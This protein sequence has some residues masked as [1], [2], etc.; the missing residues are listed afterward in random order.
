VSKNEAKRLTEYALKLLGRKSYSEAQIREKLSAKTTDK[1]CVDEAVKNLRSWRLIDDLEFAKGFIRNSLLVRPKGVRRLKF[2]LTA[3]G[4]NKDIVEE[5]IL[6]E[7]PADQTDALVFLAQKKLA[8]LGN[9]PREKKYQ[10]VMGFLLRRG[11]GYDEVKRIM[12]K[13][14]D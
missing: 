10:R 11:F 9:L 5:A 12:A 3:K 4:V 13:I 8:G 6:V 14:L 7:Y 2:E 1:N